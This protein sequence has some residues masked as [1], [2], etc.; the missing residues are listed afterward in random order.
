MKKLTIVGK[1]AIGSLSVAYYLR[2]T[3]WEIEW[4][5]DEKIPTSSVGEA[6][7][8]SLPII[9]QELFDF[10]GED[11][12]E[13]GGTPKL[14]VLKQNWSFHKFL[15]SFPGPFHALHFDMNSL[16]DFIYKKI[17]DNPRLTIKNEFISNLEDLKSDFVM[18]CSGFPI[19][20]S[21]DFNF[22]DIPVDSAY[23][24]Q[25]NWDYPKINYSLQIAKENGWVFGV[26]L[27]KRIAIGYLYNKKYSN[28]KNIE[29]DLEEIFKEYN[30][31]PNEKI[32]KIDFES[33]YRKNNFNNKIVYNGN[34]SFFIEPLEATGFSL[35]LYIMELSLQLWNGQLTEEECQEY[36]ERE[37]QEIA[38]MIL[39]HYMSG[40]IYNS[41]FWIKSKT[42]AETRIKKE[43]E[44]KTKWSEYIYKSITGDTLN[45]P[46]EVGTFGYENY[47]KNIEGLGIKEKILKMY[48]SSL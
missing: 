14:G 4:I 31:E 8:L 34:A 7:N 44:N 11:L 20:S 23:V 9:L 47:K 46:A 17:K 39:M 12:L 33:F 38:L 10:N 19:K 21:N 2:F 16:Q 45:L 26:P 3:N 22:L 35:S 6:S 48:Q 28:A 24:V 13:I 25:C 1:G 5:F 27:Q 30:I 15:H 43:F 32:T 41:E 18:V 29:K 37:V 40:S 36:Y 42:L